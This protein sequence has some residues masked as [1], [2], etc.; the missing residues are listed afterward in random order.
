MRARYWKQESSQPAKS[1]P[2]RFL[3]IATGLCDGVVFLLLLNCTLTRGGLVLSSIAVLVVL[4]FSHTS[5]SESGVICDSPT[6]DPPAEISSLDRNRESCI[7]LARLRDP[8]GMTD[9]ALRKRLDVLVKTGENR[10]CA[11]CGKRGQSTRA[12]VAILFVV[13]WTE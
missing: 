4:Y 8:V 6:R 5:R 10:F 13:P 7:P 1:K 2:L 9:Q 11:D 3:Y 12:R